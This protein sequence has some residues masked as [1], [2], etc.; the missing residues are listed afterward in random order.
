MNDVVVRPW[1]ESDLESVRRITWETWLA[2]YTAFVPEEDLR[3]YF[4]REYSLESLRT[5]FRA[6]STGGFLALDREVPSGYVRT[7]LDERDGRFYV[8][9]LYVLPE[10]QGKGVGSRLLRAAEDT[11][12]ACGAPAVWL[13]VMTANTRTVAWYRKIGFVFVE[14]LPF[15]MGNT[16]VPHL[17]GHKPR[18]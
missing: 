7:R 13:G 5:F 15:T 17:I 1:K 18:G 12:A 6:K 2:T 9:S 10:C 8:T 4:D 14:E 3:S 16:T 11:A